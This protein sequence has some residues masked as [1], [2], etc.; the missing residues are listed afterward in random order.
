ME[1]GTVHGEP[2]DSIGKR[3]GQLRTQGSLTQQALASR[4]ALSRVA[5]SHFEMDLSL[6]SERTILLLAGIFKISPVE[7]V[8]G[9]TYPLAKAERLP[10]NIAWY[11]PLELDVSLFMNDLEWLNR[12]VGK[13]EADTFK[14]DIHMKWCARFIEW[15]EAWLDEKDKELLSGA[16]E[17]LRKIGI[18]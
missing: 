4:L 10:E 17:E 18:K 13:Q 12:L 8:E 7:L 6:P 15:N 3:I 1:Q 9:T 5:I 11:T 16:W 2:M 14:Q